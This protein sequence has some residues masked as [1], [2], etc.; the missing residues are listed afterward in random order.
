MVGMLAG[1]AAA[2][3]L[4]RRIKASRFWLIFAG[5]L[6]SAPCV[7]LIG[8][9]DSLLATK[10]AA[11]AFGLSGGLAVANLYISSFD[12]VPADTRASA[13]AFM[14]LAGYMTSGFAPLVTGMWKQ[15]I[16][17]HGMMTY[18]SVLVMAAALLLLAG[19]RF[20]F[21]ADYKRVHRSGAADWRLQQLHDAQKTWPPAAFQHG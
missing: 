19:I 8:N 13:M 18:A 10:L 16:G 3:Y 4:Y 7:H 21:Q 9:S 6:L 1:A 17:I 5:L 14:N 15:S 11:I 2:D 20:L 12:V